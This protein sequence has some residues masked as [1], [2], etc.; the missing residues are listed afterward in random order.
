MKLLA[1]DSA[2]TPGA[3]YRFVVN[4]ADQAATLIRQR[5]GENARV[6]SVRSVAA[7]GWRRLV[8]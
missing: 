4:S 5:L 1:T 3:C 6:L 7:P 2:P 8:S